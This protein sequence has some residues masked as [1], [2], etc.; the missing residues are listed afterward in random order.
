MVAFNIDDMIMDNKIL[1][2]KVKNIMIAYN[3]ITIIK[4]VIF[5]YKVDILFID[6]FIDFIIINIALFTVLKVVNYFNRI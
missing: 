5:S 6:F 4:Y 1:Q 3:I 2:F